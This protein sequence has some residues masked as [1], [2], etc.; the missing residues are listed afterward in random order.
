MADSREWVDIFPFPAEWFDIMH[1]PDIVDMR[2]ERDVGIAAARQVQL[3]GNGFLELTRAYILAP[4]AVSI[5]FDRKITRM[6][7]LPSRTG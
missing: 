3:I 7:S 6:C 5:S 4:A 2:D 1:V